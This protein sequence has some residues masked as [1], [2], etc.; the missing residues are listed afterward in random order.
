MIND[1]RDTNPIITNYQSRNHSITQLLNH[2][3][4]GF[5]LVEVLVTVAIVALVVTLVTSTVFSTMRLSEEVDARDQTD[6]LVRIA[7]STLTRDLLGAVPP[8][9]TE[10]DSFVG[11]N[12]DVNGLP[13]DTATFLSFSHVRTLPDAPESDLARVS[14]AQQGPTLVRQEWRN[15]LSSAPEFSET[16]ELATGLAGF[17]LRYYD[18]AQ[19][20]D[21]WSAGVRKTLPAAVSVELT[22]D[23]PDRRSYLLLIPFPKQEL[24]AGAQPAGQ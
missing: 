15:L 9:P 13:A 8:S 16:E 14:Y 5:T 19:W 20:M 17:N 12:Q 4:K 3:S 11:Q 2:S 22:L 6:R 7:F 1:R 24:P 23:T 21:G 18:G 10:K